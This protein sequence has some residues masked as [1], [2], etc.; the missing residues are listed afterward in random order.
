MSDM[1]LG[2]C[3]PK[4][5]TAF[6]QRKEAE[7]ALEAAESEL[8]AASVTRDYWKAIAGDPV[9]AAR[10]NIDPGE[11]HERLRKAEEVAFSAEVKVNTRKLQLEDA[12]SH[13]RQ[14]AEGAA[15]ILGG[16][17]RVQLQK[18]QD[19]YDKHKAGMNEAAAAEVALIDAVNAE[20]RGCFG[21][22]KPASHLGLSF[23]PAVG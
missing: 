2:G 12:R 1:T 20:L 15:E 6:T 8:E 16:K 17:A 4:T 19:D 3:C 21:Y 11:V 5:A 10:E 13:L 18:I 9:R 22:N 23:R 7:S 14:C